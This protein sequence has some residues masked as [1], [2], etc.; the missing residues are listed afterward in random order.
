MTEEEVFIFIHIFKTGGNTLTQ[1]IEKNFPA[2]QVYARQGERILT[3]DRAGLARY[4][5]ATGHYPYSVHQFFPSRPLFGT[6]LRDPVDRA[7]S[8]Y[9]YTRSQPGDNEVHVIA[10]NTTIDQFIAHERIRTHISNVMTLFLAAE[11][12]LF[13]SRAESMNRGHLELAKKRLSEM[14][15]VGLTER[16]DESLALLRKKF[17]WPEGKGP[18]ESKNVTPNPV[19]KRDVSN[20]VLRQLSE[21]NR[22]DEELYAHAREIFDKRSRNS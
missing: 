16:F 19:R 15:F 20:A 7:L 5:Y 14:A 2:E 22:L 8:V 3:A 12:D 9:G 1:E 11:P 4:R 6:M 10:R 18:I 13:L 21:M 17:G